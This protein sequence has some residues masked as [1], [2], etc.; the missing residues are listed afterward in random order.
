MRALR[1]SPR[2]YRQT[3]AETLRDGPRGPRALAWQL[4]YF[5][6]A[7][8]LWDFLDRNH[9]RHVHAHHA[10]VAA[11][12]AMVATRF[13]NRVEGGTAWR[14]TMTVHGPE[15]FSEA[16]TRKLALKAI[17]RGRGDHDQRVRR[18]SVAGGHR[19]GD[20]GADR[21]RQ[22]RNRCRRLHASGREPRKDRLR[23]LNVAQL[24]QRKGQRVLL[25]AVRMLRREGV[26]RRP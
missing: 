1:Q 9:L 19:P 4:F 12:L 15:D 13:A 18:R 25:D 20:A 21:N 11:D 16:R 23:I 5:G 24:A 26:E 17:A 8:V 7:I 3:F 22:V 10:N 2:A 14:W 6:E